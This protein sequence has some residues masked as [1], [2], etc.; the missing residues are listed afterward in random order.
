MIE[1]C[2]IGNMNNNLQ[3]ITLIILILILIIVILFYIRNSS[4]KHDELVEKYTNT[5]SIGNSIPD[6]SHTTVLTE[7]N[8][9]SNFPSG[10]TIVTLRNCQVAFNNDKTSKYEYADEWKE[11][12]TIKEGSTST[13]YTPVPVKIIGKDNTTNETDIE[14]VNFGER[15]RCFKKMD[16]TNTDTYKYRYKDNALIK[17]DNQNYVS[18]TSN[19]N[20]VPTS[21]YYM[22]MKFD[23]PSS[24][25][26]Y[27]YFA[28]VEQSICSLNYSTSLGGSTNLGDTKLYRLK[29]NSNNII[30]KLEK[31]NINPSNNHIFSNV[32]DIDLPSL[33]STNKTS[34]Y[35]YENGKFI[36]KV[37]SSVT[38]GATGVNNINV[39]IYNFNRELFCNKD[40]GEVKYNNIKS[41]KIFGNKQFD[42]NKLILSSSANKNVD[43]PNT[44]FANARATAYDNKTKVLDHIKEVLNTQIDTANSP[45]RTDISTAQRK[46]DSAELERDNFLTSINSK[47]KYINKIL[48]ET[49]ETKLNFLLPDDNIRLNKLGFSSTDVSD[50]EIIIESTDEPVF[51]LIKNNEKQHIYITDIYTDT[52]NPYTKTFSQD[53][54]CDILIVGGG[55]GGSV[56]HGG[57]GGAGQLVFINNAILNGTYTIKVGK[58]GNGSTASGDSR[59]MGTITNGTK[60]SNS[61]F[62]SVIAEGGG[63]SVDTTLRDGGSGAGGDGHLPDGGV[64]GKG[65]KNTIVDTFSSGTVYSRGNDGGDGSAVSSGNVGQGGGGGGAGT[66]GTAGGYNTDSDIGHG[67]DG[68]SGISEINYDF[69]TNFGNYGKLEADGK[70]WFAGGGAGGTYYQWSSVVSK[71][72]RGGGGSSPASVAYTKINGENGVNGTGGGGAGGTAWWGNG[73]NGG[74]GIVIIRYRNEPKQV[75]NEKEI[76]LT[77]DNEN[78]ESYYPIEPSTNSA[79][80]TDNSYTVSVKIT[81]T[82][83][84]NYVYQL[85][86]HKITSR[87]HYHS[88]QIFTNVDNTYSGST[89]FKTY[90]G[91]AISIDLG[92][93][94][95]PT[96]MRIAPRPLQEGILEQEFQKGYPKAFKIFASDNASCW[97]DNDHSSWMLIH[98]QASS[99]TYTNE[100]YTIVNFRTN[101]PK[102]RYYTMV[103]LS[104]VGSYVGGYLHFAEWNIA[105]RIDNIDNI[106]RVEL[107]KD[108]NVKINNTSLTLLT[109]GYN[110]VMGSS[111]SKIIKISNNTEIGSYNYIDE[112]KVIF[113]YEISRSLNEIN[114]LDTNFPIISTSVINSNGYYLLDNKS[115]NKIK[116][117]KIFIYKINA[118][119]HDIELYFNNN[120]IMTKMNKGTDYI[121]RSTEDS[122]TIILFNYYIT[123]NKN[124]QGKIYLKSDNIIFN[125]NENIRGVFNNIRDDV[126]K[127]TVNNFKISGSSTLTQLNNMF[128][129]KKASVDKAAATAQLIKLND[130]T[131]PI[132]ISYNTSSINISSRN[133]LDTLVTTFNNVNSFDET[134]VAGQLQSITNTHNFGNVLSPITT[135]IDEYISYELATEKVPQTPTITSFNI[136]NTAQKYIYFKKL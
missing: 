25:N 38:G 125:I 87:D 89:R 3:N 75:G 126:F 96:K 69:K 19:V 57:G 84:Y 26:N 36:Y 135:N 16:S 93:S 98:D 23:I 58:G 8:R 128:G 28:N 31:I 82:P 105:G 131:T 80:W 35:V 100:Q 118:T 116:K 54:I 56:G 68:L 34:S 81:D 85:F 73:G 114:K 29:L 117:Y 108:T 90:A 39:D 14:F 24:T 97:N 115:I 47:S 120:D 121:S 9:L 67:G 2:S 83:Y 94:I 46:I 86:N 33:L 4:L 7:V 63:I 17:Y 113:K 27:N 127:E 43:I 79:T 72:G 130:S 119:I 6:Q 20:G 49:D 53:T 40:Q 62:G 104:T 99:L 66:A 50:S 61:Q 77:F 30:E 101:L 91:I 132:S 65:L 52:T 123:I 5:T 45:V 111:S 44:I 107:V 122:G 12:E 88:Q 133:S 71:G 109:G 70:Y 59:T 102:Y 124:I 92:R 74:S 10:G 110:I 18:L 22:E 1:K 55:G 78:N 106:Y 41:Y 48:T 60:G 129:V 76:T 13:T 112:N 21:N 95:Y 11:I 37:I 32:T 15:S 42:V 64:G 134:K 136:Q 103:V 51:S